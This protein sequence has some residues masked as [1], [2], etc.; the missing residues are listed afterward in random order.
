[1]V[2]E[3][4]ANAGRMGARQL[5]FMRRALTELYYEAGVLTG[6]PK[7]QNGPL[8]HLQDE[9]EVELIRNERQNLGEDLMI[10][11]LEPY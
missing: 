6:D 1:M 10:F 2:A 3:L 8:G 9:R 5:G 4:F 7:L 11:I